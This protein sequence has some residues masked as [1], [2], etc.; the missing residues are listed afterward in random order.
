MSTYEQWVAENESTIWARAGERG[1]ND[2]AHLV[3]SV[4]NLLKLRQSFP[5]IYPS[6]VDVIDAAVDRYLRIR[7]TFPLSPP[8]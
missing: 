5:S 7:A 3:H 6:D 2:C 1:L 8:P 4:W